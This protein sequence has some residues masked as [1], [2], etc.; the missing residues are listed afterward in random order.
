MILLLIWLMTCIIVEV[1]STC[2]YHSQQAPCCQCLTPQLEEIETKIRQ[3]LP[4]ID[5]EA[6]ISPN[7]CIKTFNSCSEIPQNNPSGYYWIQSSVTQINR[8]YCDMNR[9][10][11]GRSIGGWMRVAYLNMSD[12]D[13]ECPSGFRLITSP[14]RLCGRGTQP[15]VGCTSVVYPVHGHQYTRVCGKIIG[16]QFGDTDAFFGGN[17]PNATIDDF[18]ADGVSL[19]HGSPRNH[20]WTFT[21]ALD[22]SRGNHVVCPCTR[23]DLGFTGRVP[24]FVGDDY[25]CE[26]GTQVYSPSSGVYIQDPLWN[27]DGCGP[28]STCCSFNSP[29]WF[30]KQLPQPTTDDIE[31]RVCSFNPVRVEDTPLELVEI[32][33]Q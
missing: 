23:P 18:Y 25:F 31:M 24:H 32:Y 30:C 12:P 10:C 27:G 9:S 3:I 5:R 14:I 33:V 13:Q 1:Q 4:S 29:P 15:I 16:Y 20:I 2:C 22:E 11:C 26:T 17:I 8:E 28:R 19:T 7:P 6:S 21:A